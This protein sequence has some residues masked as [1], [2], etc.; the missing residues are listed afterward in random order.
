MTAS[1]T[2]VF[3]PGHTITINT[4]WGDRKLKFHVTATEFR[5]GT[6]VTPFMEHLYRVSQEEYATLRESVPYAKLYRYNPKH[7]EHIWDP[8]SILC[9]RNQGPFAW[10]KV[11]G[12]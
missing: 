8:P 12:S 7:L 6:V 1:E 3:Q 10:G 4:V 5:F 2:S 11:G 9:N